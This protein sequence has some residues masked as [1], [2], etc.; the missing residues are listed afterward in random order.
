MSTSM[1]FLIYFIFVVIVANVMRV[2]AEVWP[3]APASLHT[4]V[5][6]I[7]A[8]CVLIPIARAIQRG[9]GDWR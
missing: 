5:L 3:N 1:D 9:P 7:I 4:G 6:W 2:V 8:V